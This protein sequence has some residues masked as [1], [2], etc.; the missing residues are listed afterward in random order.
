MLLC[1]RNND[2]PLWYLLKQ[3]AL[4]REIDFYQI[5]VQFKDWTC[6]EITPLF[7]TMLREVCNNRSLLRNRFST[8]VNWIFAIKLL[9]KLIKA[10]DFPKVNHC[11]QYNYFFESCDAITGQVTK[12]LK[13]MSDQNLVNIQINDLQEV[14]R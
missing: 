9:Q 12:E 2:K 3:R 5:C 11:Y 10:E 6:T 13:R 7:A 8:G 4:Q 14:V 1:I